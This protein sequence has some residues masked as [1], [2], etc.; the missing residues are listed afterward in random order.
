[1][2]EETKE[3]ARGDVVA[4]KSGGPNMTVAYTF[5]DDR[6]EIKPRYAKAYYYNPVTGNIE[7]RCIAIDLLQ[8]V[9]I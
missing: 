7:Y 6:Y 5:F 8:V 4:L 3:I 9:R 2:A 1:M